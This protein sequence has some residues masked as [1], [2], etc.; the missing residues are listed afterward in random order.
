MPDRRNPWLITYPVPHLVWEALLLFI[1]RLSSRRQLGQERWAGA[2]H[3][4][5]DRLAGTQTPRAAHPDT[6]N[7]YLEVTAPA[8]LQALVQRPVRHLINSKVL[9]F[10]RLGDCFLV[11]IDG[12]GIYTTTSRHCPHCLTQCHPN[13]QV[14]YYHNVL[15]AK[16]VTPNGL[17]FS[18]ASEFIQNTEPTATKQDCERKA[19]YRLLPKLRQ[20]F[21][22]L[23]MCLLLDAGFACKEV[24]DQLALHRCEGLI[25]FK[26]GSLPKLWAEAQSQVRCHPANRL[27]HRPDR[28]TRQDLAWVTNLQHEGRSAHAIFCVETVTKEDQTTT[29]HYG[30]IA[31]LRPS[32][33]NVVGLANEGGRQ[34]WKI[35][36]QGFNDQ[37]NG[38]F[39]LG[40]GYGTM[41]HAWQN[42]YYLLQLAHLLSQLLIKGDL[43]AKLLRHG[44]AT[45]TAGRRYRGWTWHR[46]Y[47]S[48]KHFIRCLGQ[49]FVAARFSPLTESDFA[50]HIQIRLN[51]A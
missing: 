23:P 33:R 2:F 12:T 15:E 20:A 3:D 47:Q 34:R 42:W 29:T 38:G 13:G 19:F 4:N 31:T 36:N 48:V 40:H 11:P 51:T 5:L 10:A 50:R 14:L 32:A 46:F 43:F 26:E 27:R 25:T 44:A 7:S 6:V 35:E 28:Q 30:W 39:E 18:L 24:L 1:L 16:L 17:A 37:K 49:A 45:P 8:H 9:D 21:P 22:R 41:G